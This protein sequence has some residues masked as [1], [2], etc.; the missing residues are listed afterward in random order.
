MTIFVSW[1]TTRHAGHPANLF[2]AMM[3]PEAL[4]RQEKGDSFGRDALCKGLGGGKEHMILEVDVAVKIPFELGE[5]GKEGAIGV[6]RVPGRL[7]S[8]GQFAEPGE[9]GAGILVLA[10]HARD[11]AVER[12]RPTARRHSLDR[13]EEHLLFLQHV[14]VEFEIERVEDLVDPDERRS[15]TTVHFGDALCHRLEARQFASEKGVM[16]GDDVIGQF[17]RRKLCGIQ[18]LA[19][20]L[21]RLG[22]E[23]FDHRLQRDGTSLTS[24]REG[25]SA[26]ATEVDA[27]GLEYPGT[28]RSFGDQLADS[29][30]GKR[31]AGGGNKDWMFHDRVSLEAKEGLIK[32]KRGFFRLFACAPVFGPYGSLP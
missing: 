8:T 1:W 7:E 21:A 28:T 17:G 3:T 13:G 15:V 12:H 18:P 14:A 24:L 4:V 10:Q 20:R 5:P 16:P 23:L 26:L 32:N 31:C 27:E 22:L 29:A 6:A 30:P 9:V 2:A 11:G 25:G 19:G